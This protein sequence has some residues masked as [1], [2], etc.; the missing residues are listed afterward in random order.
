M[1]AQNYGPQQQIKGIDWDHSQNCY[2][3]ERKRLIK[4]L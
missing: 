1:Q 4:I 2:L 3:I